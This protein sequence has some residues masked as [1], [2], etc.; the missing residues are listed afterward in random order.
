MMKQY[1][2]IKEAH[3]DAILFFRLGDF[4]EMFKGDAEEVSRILSLTLTQRHGIPMCGIPYH[5]AAGYIGRL[6]KAGK[7]IAICEQVSEPGKGKGIVEREVVEIITPGTVVNDDY[8]NQQGNNYI[9]AFA[10]TAKGLSL[11]YADIS[12]GELAATL[13]ASGSFENQIRKEWGRLAPREIL[14]QESLGSELPRL[15]RYLKEEAGVSVNFLPDWYFDERNGFELLTDHFQTNNLKAFGMNHDDGAVPAAGVLLGYLQ[16]T[17]RGILRH[18]SHIDRYKDDQFLAMDESTQRNLEIDKPLLGENREYTLFSEMNDTRTAMGSRLLKSWLFHPLKDQ[19]PL[20]ERLDALEYLYERQ[21]LLTRLREELKKSRDL[22]RLTSRLA[23]DKAHA[24]DVQAIAQSL[25]QILAIRQIFQEKAGEEVL[26]KL[27]GW[28][29]GAQ[30]EVRLEELC[31]RIRET[32]TDDPSIVLSEGRLIREGF[33]EELD[34]KRHI[35]GNARKILEEYRLEV[36]EKTGLPR[37]KLGQNKIIGTY[38]EVTKVNVSKVPEDFIR[39]QS[40]VN[41]ERYTT[42][43]LSQMESEINNAWERS[44][45]M[46]RDIFLDLR[47]TLKDE[48]LLLKKGAQTMALWDVLQSLARMATLK[49]WIR[50]HFHNQHV[51]AVKG[52]RHPVVESHLPSGEF[53]PNDIRLGGENPPFALI[54]GPNMAG[55]STYLRQTALIVLMAQCG[56]FVPAQ[57]AVVGIVDKIFCRVGASDNLARGE[58]TFLVEMNETAHILRTASDQS[59][60]IMDEVGRGTSTT[61][62]LAIAQAVSEYLMDE[63]KART[64]FA[65]HYHELTRLDHPGLVN[66]SLSVREHRGSVVFLKQVVQGA[67]SHSYGIHVGRLAGLPLGVVR[68]ADDILQQLEPQDLTPR[69]EPAVRELLFDERDVVVD[70][71]GRFDPLNTTP[72]KALEMIDKWKKLLSDH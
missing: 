19:A 11:A 71:I 17:S 31:R 43:R 47:E 24:K 50:P 65:T 66:L 49:G 22:E 3:R 69:A 39:R 16:E 54:T 51:L 45:E 10:L 38:F 72:I 32:L 14:C 35:Q 64:L 58:S 29:F 5:A 34:H 68:R 44:V 46:E 1:Q 4:Y 55:K 8:L 70:E 13:I 59:L 60:I 42:E 62:G 53:V 41:A 25:E 28:N 61:D 67:A 40:L 20:E 18:I 6:L 36:M 27:L 7:K 57:E 12:T 23:L 52:G 37:L 33:S 9:L 15:Y 2:K 48:V 63:V 26:P 56:S 21:L 30:E